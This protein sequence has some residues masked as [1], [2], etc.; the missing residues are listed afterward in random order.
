MKRAFWIILLVLAAGLG[1]I[2]VRVLHGPVDSGQTVAVIYGN[3]LDRIAARGK[4]E[5]K[6]TVD[7]AGKV[8]GRIQSIAAKEGEEVAKDQVVITMD[9][10]YA[11]AAVDQGRAELKDAELNYSRSRRLLQSKAAS[12]AQFDEASA[13]RDLARAHLEMA[14]ALLKDMH[15]ASPISG[16]VIA[17]YRETGESV[18]AGLPILTIADVSAVRVRAEIDE[19][20]VGRLA[21]G[22]EASITSDAYPGRVFTGKVIEIGERVGKRSIKLEDPSKITDTKV[23]E[24]KI[25]L[26]NI[27]SGGPCGEEGTGSSDAPRAP[28][29]ARATLDACLPPFKLGMTVDVKIDVVRRDHVLKIPRRVLQQDENGSYVKVVKEGRG[30][31]PPEIRRVVL[32][33]MDRWDVEVLQGLKERE[34]VVVP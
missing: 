7:L 6:T 29:Q 33:A 21:L 10:E 26:K 2:G 31:G 15:I 20:D 1:V 18:K 17:K 13:K 14:E 23:L 28:A 3:I 30:E 32:G 5:A 16:K 34:K 22:Q 27:E 8:D 24:A 4:V 12:T 19:D 9:D 25:E 11:K